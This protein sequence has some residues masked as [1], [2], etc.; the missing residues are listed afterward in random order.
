MALCGVSFLDEKKDDHEANLHSLKNVFGFSTV[1]KQFSNDHS[2]GLLDTDENGVGNDRREKIDFGI[3]KFKLQSFASL[4]QVAA[5]VRK[6]VRGVGTCTTIKVN[7]TDYMLTCAHNLVTKSIRLGRFVGHTA[8]Y[9]YGMRQGENA[10]NKLYKLD[11]QNIH[12]H[13]DFNGEP[14]CGYD[15]AL[16]AYSN[17]A[18]KRNGEVKFSKDFT[19][20]ARWGRGDPKMLKVGY[21]VEVGGYPGEKDGWPHYHTGEI[22]AIQETE[23]KGW[24]IFYNIDSTPG[25]SGSPIMIVDK[26][27][28]CEEDWA[29]GIRK[30]IIGV[31]TGHDIVEGLN[32]G[33][34]LTPA[35]EKWVDSK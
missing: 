15:I 23:Q 14:Y 4:C 16:C 29:K 7:Q 31:H 24:I 18:D 32:Y 25:M 26:R 19:S 12:V 21:K 1:Q 11:P 9:V 35:L 8:G 3:Q 5:N 30:M 28:I 6:G 13:P 34:L 2:E 20:D 10:W 17:E 27:Y 22:T 33:T